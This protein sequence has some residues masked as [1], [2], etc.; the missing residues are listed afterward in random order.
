MRLPGYLLSLI[1][2]IGP[3]IGHGAN[4]LKNP[5]FDAGIDHWVAASDALIDWDSN[6]D[7]DGDPNSGSMVIVQQDGDV[8]AAVS[9]ADCVP[10]TGGTEHSFGGHIYVTSDQPGTPRVLMGL[11]LYDGPNCTGAGLISPSTSNIVSSFDTW[12]MKST[13][14]VIDD[15]AVSARLR[16]NIFNLTTEPLKIRV[17]SMFILGPMIFEDGFED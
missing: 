10:V 14:A 8:D 16:I 7:V 12:I 15:F 5:N 3:G 1:I 17:D 6:D 9:Q 11:S 2:L 4:L 13:T